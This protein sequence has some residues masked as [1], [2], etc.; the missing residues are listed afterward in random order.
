M[1]EPPQSFEKTRRCSGK[2]LKFSRHCS[3]SEL[4]ENFALKRK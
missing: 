4:K 2:P 3:N 1:K